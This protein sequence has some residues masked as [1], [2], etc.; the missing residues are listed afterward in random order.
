[1]GARYYIGLDL[2]DPFA[3][4]TRPCDVAVLGPDLDCTF[5]RWDYKADG[6]GIIPL[7][8]VGRSF[9]LAIDGP[10]AL[11]GPVNATVRESERIVNAPGRTPYDLPELGKPFAGFIKGSVQLFYNLVTSGSRF[12]LLGME[13]VPPGDANL[14]EV[15]PGG[16]WRVLAPKPLPA[17]RTLDG[18]TARRDLLRKL[19]VTFPNED[20]PTDDQLDA[21]IAAYVAWAYDQGRAKVVGA[22]PYLDDQ[23]G[24]IREGYV[25]QPL[26]PGEAPDEPDVAPV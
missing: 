25:V 12:R 15:F 3:I 16:A 19:G 8:A 14:F 21:A 11:A 2:S 18:R 4:I 22:A 1:M 9:L 10:Q 24:T 23:T 17:K 7:R 13:D 6:A 20:L 26:R 5:S